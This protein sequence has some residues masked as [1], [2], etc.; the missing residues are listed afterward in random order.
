MS[1]PERW[2]QVAEE[3]DAR[4]V[5]I[6]IDGRIDVCFPNNWVF[7]IL[8]FNNI[9]FLFSILRHFLTLFHSG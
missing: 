9:L 3:E 1:F 2:D 6:E 5:E 4:T 8:L 7:Y